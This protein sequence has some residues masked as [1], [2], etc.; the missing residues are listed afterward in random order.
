M[1]MSEPNKNAPPSP[2][3]LG[4]GDVS[5]PGSVP[6]SRLTLLPQAV[7]VS[8]GSQMHAVQPHVHAYPPT[9][10]WPASATELNGP[11]ELVLLANA[12]D[13]TTSITTAQKYAD[14]FESFILWPPEKGSGATRRVGLN[15]A[16]L[17][18]VFRAAKDN[19]AQSRALLRLAEVAYGARHY[20]A[21]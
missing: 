21:L 1:S 2:D 20:A 19:E 5:L 8:P 12:G 13:S 18:N 16:I 11:N 9:C 10:V 7:R 17:L 3:D 6:G 4:A 14:T 15:R